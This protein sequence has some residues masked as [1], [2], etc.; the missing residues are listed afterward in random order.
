[1]ALTEKHIGTIAKAVQEWLQPGNRDLK[2]AIDKTV[3][4]G[5]FALH[6]IQHQVRHLK[7]SVT[8][9]NLLRWAER[10]GLNDAAPK[11]KSILCLH[12]GNLP[13]VGFQDALAV[14]M[15]GENY[16]GKVSR[17]DPWLL[18][19]FLKFAEEYGL[20]KSGSWSHQLDTFSGSKADLLIFAG[21]RDSVPE[22]NTRLKELNIISDQTPSLIRTAHFS[23]AWITD[24]TPETMKNLTEAVFRY[25]G[26]GC[27]SAAVVVAPFHL[28]SEKCSFTDY[29]ESFWLQNPQ[30]EKPSPKLFHR[31]AYNKAAGISQA[32]LN[33]FLIEENEELLDEKFV[34][35]WIKGGEGQLAEV[36][37]KAGDSLQSV[38]RSDGK[39]MEIAGKITEPLSI[40]Q[41]PPVWWKPDGVDTIEW[42]KS[43]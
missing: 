24:H 38:Y 25:G 27:R 17:K 16:L 2:Q 42:I 20:A 6:D 4:E 18:P 15:T 13:L 1:M 31:Y 14:M 23:I 21:S 19:S 35:K 37:Q 33:D 36:I 3:S 32:W 7:Q 10:S 29:V 34:L 28:D 26:N 41:T 30:H 22:V 8:E 40:A 5:H 43:H 12:A 9:K 11:G 39:G